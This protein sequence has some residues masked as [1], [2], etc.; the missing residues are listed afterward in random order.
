MVI[1]AM[2]NGEVLTRCEVPEEYLQPME[3]VSW[4]DNYEFRKLLV[5]SY[6]A[7]FMQKMEKV[8]KETYRVEYR[9]VFKSKMSKDEIDRDDH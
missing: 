2:I 3:G 8:F 6:L 7:E 1:E 9:L 5:N 4:Q